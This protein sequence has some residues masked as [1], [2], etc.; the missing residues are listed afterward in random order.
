MSTYVTINL[1]TTEARAQY[2]AAAAAAGQSMSTYGYPALMGLLTPPVQGKLDA[3]ARQSVRSNLTGTVTNPPGTFDAENLGTDWGDGSDGNPVPA[4]YARSLLRVNVHPNFTSGAAVYAQASAVG[5]WVDNLNYRGLR[6]LAVAG[7]TNTANYLSFCRTYGVKWLMLGT[8]AQGTES[9]ATVVNR[10]NWIADHAA[11]VCGGI[12]GI[13]EPSHY[14]GTDWFNKTLHYQEL[15]YTTV[16]GLS[17]LDGVPVISAAMHEDNALTALKGGTN[18]W[19]QLAASGLTDH[20]D[21]AALHTYP[22]GD[23]PEG[24]LDYRAGLVRAAWPGKPLWVTETGFSD[25]WAPYDEQTDGAAYGGRLALTFVRRGIPVYQYE[26]L[27]DAPSAQTGVQRVFGVVSTGSTDTAALNTANWAAKPIGTSLK[28]VTDRWIDPPG[29]T[30]YTPAH[31]TCTVSTT[32]T[33]VKTLLTATKAQSDAGI[34]DL[35]LYRQAAPGTTAGANVSVT[36][37]DRVG[38]RTFTDVGAAVKLVTTR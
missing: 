34:A 17:A 33:N 25:A 30:A 27:D 15:I 9:D 1:R 10:I 14:A 38:A 36:V 28:A 5:G 12:E 35:F 18:Y 3:V 11:D 26:L 23:G 31:V 2:A 29:T 7:A 13:N 16:R 20:F 24:Q 19:S 8:T 21:V 6:G 37:T 32:A 4:N 22:Y